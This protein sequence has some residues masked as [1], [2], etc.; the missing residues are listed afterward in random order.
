MSKTLQLFIGLIL[1]IFVPLW[2]FII[3]PELLKLPANISY[4][5][6]LIHTENNRFNI[7]SDW[8]GKTIAISSSNL[9]TF[10]SVKN[11]S[12][13]QSLFKVE[14]LMGEVLFELNQNFKVDRYSRHNLPGGNDAEGMAQVMFAPSVSKKPINFWAIE[15]GAPTILTYVDSKTIQKLN[16]YHF[17]TTDA[18]I[19]DT[20]GFEFLS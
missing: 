20:L 1:V 3:S 10:T 14:S 12:T 18:I 17:R 15:M 9:K 13:L 7:D 8:T 2:V 16:T 6:N 11:T 19:D 5:A 4:K